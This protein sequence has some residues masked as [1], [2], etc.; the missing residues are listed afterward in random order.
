[1]KKYNFLRQSFI[2]ILGLVTIPL[3][4]IPLALEADPA[5]KNDV[6]FAL[7]AMPKDGQWF[8][9]AF[10]EACLCTDNTQNCYGCISPTPPN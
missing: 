1:M 10:I 2:V 9:P 6:T 7:S 4:T 8:K 3:L 5:H